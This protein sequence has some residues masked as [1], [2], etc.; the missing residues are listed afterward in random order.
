MSPDDDARSDRRIVLVSGSPAAG[1]TTV[2]IPLAQALGLP[3]IAKDDFKEVLI[4]ILGDRDGD[5][6]WS[7][8]IGSAAWTLLW[9]MAERAPAAVIEANFRPDS[10]YE[11]ERLL[12]L[13]ARI[14]EVYCRCPFAVLSRR[15]RERQ[16]TAHA[17]HPLRTMP[18][19]WATEFARP[20]GLGAVIEVDT[21]QPVD[22]EAL[23]AQ[24]ARLLA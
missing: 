1:K 13:D 16:Q 5:L 18:A 3:L 14:V 4:D 11:R 21:T 10:V 15:F 8:T 24:A 23:A 2:A 12:R 6:A 19:S 17:A 20:M 22:V 9:K 7:R